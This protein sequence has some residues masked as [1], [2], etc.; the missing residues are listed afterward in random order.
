MSGIDTRGFSL[1]ELMIT[2]AII[3]ILAAVAYPSY[4]QYVLR[5]ARAEAAAT[6]M[7]VAGEM[8]RHYTAHG[9]YKCANDDDSYDLS[10]S[11]S[12]RTG[13]QRYVISLCAVSGQAFV[14]KATPTGPQTTDTQCGALGLS[15]TGQKYAQ[16]GDV[17][18][19]ANAAAAAACW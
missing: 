2:V 4:Q 1:I 17:C 11:A 14:L 10:T 19:N 16:L 6:L 13:A 18:T 12:P 15:S 8:E 9:C 7:E 3:G 5:S